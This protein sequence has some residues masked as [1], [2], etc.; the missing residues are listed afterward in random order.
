MSTMTGEIKGA[1]WAHKAGCWMTADFLERVTFKS[2][3]R[4]KTSRR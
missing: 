4:I 2:R 1:V 3:P